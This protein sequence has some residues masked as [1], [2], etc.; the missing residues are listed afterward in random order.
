MANR[1]DTTK[2]LGGSRY[3]VYHVYMASDGASG[4]LDG[5][6]IIN[7]S[8]EDMGDNTTFVVEEVQ[9]GF[10]GFSGQLHFDELVEDTFIWVLPND[11]GPQMNFT[12]WGGLHDRG[13]PLDSNG[14]LKLST[15][16][17]TEIGDVGSL[18]V[19]VRLNK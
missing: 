6:V 10:V 2:I 12:P 19:K 11:A 17:F 9:W 16:G 14:Q 18:I 15:I 8:T 5:Q 1:V 4:E 13:N 7:P 3:L